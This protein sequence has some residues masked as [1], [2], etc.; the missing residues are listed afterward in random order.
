MEGGRRH[1][2][3]NFS[4]VG[5]IRIVIFSSDVDKISAILRAGGPAEPQSI[6]A[7]Q[8]AYRL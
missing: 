8:A 1:T 5:D 3:V 6:V 4:V 7:R 2:L